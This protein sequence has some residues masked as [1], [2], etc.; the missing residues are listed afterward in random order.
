MLYLSS[1]MQAAVDR[2]SSDSDANTD[3]TA[4][5]AELLEPGKIGRPRSIFVAQ[6]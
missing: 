1:K 6:K 2:S 4:D 3:A 5:A